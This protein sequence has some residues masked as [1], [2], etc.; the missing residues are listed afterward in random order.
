MGE[1]EIIAV[2]DINFPLVCKNSYFFVLGAKIIYESV[3]PSFAHSLHDADFLV[4]LISF[5]ITVIERSMCAK[6]MMWG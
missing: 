1:G 4:H 2:L 6:K 5:T 3:C